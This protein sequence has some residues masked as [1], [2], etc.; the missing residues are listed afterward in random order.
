MT[1]IKNLNTQYADSWTCDVA[2]G[3]TICYFKNVA[4]EALKLDDYLE[5]GIGDYNYQIP[6]SGLTYS[7]D[8]YEYTEDGRID[9]D[10]F[11]VPLTEKEET[12]RLG[13]PFFV[14]F[15][16]IFDVE[17]DQL[18][19]AVGSGAPDGTAITPKSAN[20]LFLSQE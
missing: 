19:L 9:C 1:R 13:D 4:C 5:L 15:T 6:L 8:Y 7:S 16:P 17:N 10:F 20:A 2:S 12:I 14:S 18:G 11:V 3:N